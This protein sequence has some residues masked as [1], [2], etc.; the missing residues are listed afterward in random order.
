M[1]RTLTATL[2]CVFAL[3]A[4]AWARTDLNGTYSVVMT[5][6]ASYHHNAFTITSSDDT[7]AKGTVTI[8]WSLGPQAKAPNAD[9]KVWTVPFEAKWAK[10]GGLHFQVVV[11]KI[12]P[13]HYQFEIFPTD[14]PKPSLVGVC[15]VSRAPSRDIQAAGPW[16]HGVIASKK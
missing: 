11:G 15:T 10:D 6:D 3:Y 7:S 1:M 2:L 5:D 8:D 4:A 16:K 12:T 14:G 13:T 9:E